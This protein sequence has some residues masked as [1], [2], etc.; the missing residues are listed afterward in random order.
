ME[1]DP[2]KQYNK[3]IFSKLFEANND[4][5]EKLYKNTLLEFD[6]EN[7][8]Q[9]KNL[10]DE[11]NPEL[12]IKEFTHD[13]LLK[14]VAMED[15][16][17]FPPKNE[18]IQ[19]IE[20]GNLIEKEEPEKLSEEEVDF[21]QKINIINYLTFS[22]FGESFFPNKKNKEI[23]NNKTN[24]ENNESENSFLNNNIENKKESKLLD[25]LD[26]EYDNYVINNDLLFNISMGYIDINKL[27]KE[28]AV[29]KEN[30][31]SKNERMNKAKK[32]ERILAKMRSENLDKSEFKYEV[33]FKQD[34]YD[35]LQRFAIKYKNNEYFIDIIKA[36][37]KD[38]NL[39]K[40]LERNSEKN[41]LLI[42]WEKEFKDKNL[43]YNLYIQKKERTERKQIKL[44]KEMEQK[45]KDEK[46]KNIEEQ[47]KLE[48]ELNKIRIKAMRRNSVYF[49]RKNFGNKSIESSSSNTYVNKILNDNKSSIE[50]K[51]KVKRIQ[52]ISYRK[53]DNEKSN[54]ISWKKQ[55]NDYAF[56]NL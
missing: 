8:N 53:K 46:I 23:N 37:Y 35:S 27:K 29:S 43:K 17:L 32:K 24:E 36:F 34:L 28:N 14:R 39:L 21:L 56:G 10:E 49:D 41:K 13:S 4:Q 15:Y 44:K 51:G 11:D 7:H 5:D 30:F 12:N 45:M 40:K 18:P 19:I 38:M 50:R 3:K 1:N 48:T 31:V 26:F 55:N 6:D 22:P 2:V 9:N 20:D 42:K 25:I 52:T 33:I 47:K 16:I 54:R